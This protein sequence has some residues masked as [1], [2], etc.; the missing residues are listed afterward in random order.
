[1][2]KLRQ[3]QD[4]GHD[5]TF[6]VGTYTSLV[7]DPSDKD[8]LRPRRAAGGGQGRSQ[9]EPFPKNGAAAALNR[10]PGFLGP[11]LFPQA[12][13]R[14]PGLWIYAQGVLAWIVAVIVLGTLNLT[15]L[16]VGQNNGD[17]N[18]DFPLCIVQTVL[19][20]FVYTPLEFFL[21]FLSAVIGGLVLRK[22][23]M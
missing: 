23:S 16:C 5:V 12:F 17:G 11:T 4:L 22:R 15:P 8:R 6:L 13:K 9:P 2:R 10:G 7:G 20:A 21:L 1:M 19:V 14:Y 18:N 3:F